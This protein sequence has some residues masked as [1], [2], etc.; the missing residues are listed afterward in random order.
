MLLVVLL[1]LEVLGRLVLQVRPVLKAP[2]RLGFLVRHLVRSVLVR[3][4][5]LEV[6]VVQRF[7]VKHQFLVVLGFQ[8]RLGLLGFLVGLVVRVVLEGKVCM[9]E[10]WLVHM[11]LLVVFQGFRERRVHR[12]FLGLHFCLGLL[13]DLLVPVNNSHHSLV[14]GLRRLHSQLDER[15]G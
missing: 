9:V 14:L 6:L 11:E 2:R 12:A 13:V 10:E 5:V 3:L 8:L 15:Y 7:Q 4:V 1:V